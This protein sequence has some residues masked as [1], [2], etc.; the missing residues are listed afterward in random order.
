MHRRAIAMAAASAT[1]V[2][3]LAT[4]APATAAPKEGAE[5]PYVVIMAAEP[6]LAYDGGVSGIPATQPAPGKKINPRAANVK[7]YRAHLEKKQRET[8]SASGIKAEPRN[9]ITLAVNA[10]AVSLTPTEAQK[11]SLAKGVA[12]V[13]EDVLKQKQTDVSPTFLG[14]DGKKE[15]WATGYTGKGVVVGVIDSGIWPEHPSF[16]DPGGLPAHDQTVPCEFGDADAQAHNPLDKP[17]TCQNKL[18]GARDMTATYKELTG[19]TDQEY[20][21]ARDSDGHGTHTASTAAGNRDVEAAIFGIDRG[22]VS[23]VAPE[24]GIIAYKGLGALGG[25]SSDLAAA[26]D[27]AVED[28]VDVINYSIGSASPALGPDDLAFLFAAQ[29]GVFVATSAGNA[30]PGAST[31]GSPAAVP[32]LTTVGAST[33]N[34]TFEATATV[35]AAPSDSGDATD[36][37]GKG[38]GKGKPKGGNAQTF[39]GASVTEG[40]STTRLV[41]AEDHGNPLCLTDV[42]FTPSVA[43]AVVLC[44]RGENARVDKSKAVWE[45][46]GAGMILYNQTDAQALV[47]DNHFLPSVHIT[48]SDGIAIKA[49]IDSAGEGATASL[50]QG[51]KAETQGDVMADFS[52]RGPVG[53]PGDPNIIRPD[54]TAPGVNIL[55][56]NTP[57]PETGRPGQLFQSI[58]GTSM[59]SP[60]VAGLYALLKQAHPD[61]SSAVAKSAVMTTAR[62]DV[63]KEDGKTPAD[64][65]DFGAGHV[66]PGQPS[67]RG[68]IF[69]PGIAFDAGF[70]EY[71]AY[72]CGPYPF[73]FSNPAATCASLEAAGFST[74]PSN[75]NIASIGIAEVA[76]T[77]TVERTIT[78]V[79][80]RRLDLKA[81]V[82][83]PAGYAVSVS[84]AR[85]TLRPGE[86]ATVEVTVTNQSA[87]LGEWRFGS[88][89][90]KG[91]GYDARIP[92]AVAGT[93]LKAPGTVSHT[94]AS[95]S[96]SAQIDFGYTGPF[97]VQAFGLAKD[98]PLAGSVGQDPGSVFSPSDV[99]NG[100]TVHPVDLTGVEFWRMTLN[101]SDLTG[102][103]AGQADL[104]VYVYGPDGALVADSGAGATNELIELVD[105][106]PGVYQVYVHGWATGNQTVDYTAHTW[107]VTGPADTGTLQVTAAPETAT[108]GQGGTVEYSWSGAEPGTEFGVLLYSNGSSEL[109][110]TLVT[111]DN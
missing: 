87:N 104:D 73:I 69:D 46:G 16:A 40:V 103:T 68:S 61:W 60:H 77:R 12:Q 84:P 111:V 2:G 8:L 5:K 1:A 53:S 107:S 80:T 82:D 44:A 71:L 4:M 45:Q 79:S 100:A 109:G 85:V 9:Q 50:T 90:W 3:M 28:G 56:G 22:T 21:S 92:V 7:K 54:V 14:L 58:S 97:S 76:G 67:K 78:N 32:W 39:T 81:H 95:G 41:D 55:A 70:N 74:D 24:A 13:Q 72:A 36:G 110:R 66:D 11:L 37:K 101:Q 18:I 65:F 51:E 99:G 88:V 75:L 6:A 64:P 62:Q 25:Y 47:T 10:F 31:I 102:P 83:S 33:H 27:Q 108:I 52:S 63:V 20:D 91:T 98:T 26:I 96:G 42:D 105:P 89:T 29:A 15:A 38:K 35:G 49:Y 17:F 57:T 43:G 19:L 106:A 93:A 30:G 23:G 86:D 48:Y 59:S 34:R 94:G